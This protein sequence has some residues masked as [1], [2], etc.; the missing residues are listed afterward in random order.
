MRWTR[1]TTKA[2]KPDPNYLQGEGW[3]ICRINFPANRRYELWS[4]SGKRCAAWRIASTDEEA[5]RAVAELKELAGE[6]LR[7]STG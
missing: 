7:Q 2:G 1:G 4:E 5:A 3:T 6:T